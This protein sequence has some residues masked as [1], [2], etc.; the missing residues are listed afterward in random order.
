MDGRFT[1]KWIKL[2]ISIFLIR[3]LFLRLCCDRTQNVYIYCSFHLIEAS[4]EENDQKNKQD[5]GWVKLK[6]IVFQI[7]E[8]EIDELKTWQTNVLM[9]HDRFMKLPVNGSHLVKG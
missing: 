8:Q 7:L 3:R 4:V 1:V 5:E 9:K 6:E 2:V